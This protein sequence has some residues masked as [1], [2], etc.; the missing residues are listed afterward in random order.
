MCL[1]VLFGSFRHIL[2]APCAS[3]EWL[4]VMYLGFGKFALIFVEGFFGLWPKGLAQYA[5]AQM[6]AR[7]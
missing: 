1:I 2:L 3:K 5:H 7:A 4:R 6:Q